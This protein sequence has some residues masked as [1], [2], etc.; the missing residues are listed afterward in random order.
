MLWHPFWM[1]SIDQ[2]IDNQYIIE[3]CHELREHERIDE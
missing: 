3:I 1:S 2:T